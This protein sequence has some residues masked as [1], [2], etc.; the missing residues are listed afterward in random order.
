[1]DIILTLDFGTIETSVPD[2]LYLNLQQHK[3]N[4]NIIMTG[5]A[6]TWNITVLT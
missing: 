6:N 2:E 1:M 5:Y 3:Y 4:G